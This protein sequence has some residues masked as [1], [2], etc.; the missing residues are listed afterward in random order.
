VMAR[1]PPKSEEHRVALQEVMRRD[2][3]LDEVVGVESE[4]YEGYVYDLMMPGEPHNYFSDGVFSHNCIDEIDKMRPEDRSAI[5]E[6]MEQQSYHPSF[7][8][9]F[10][11]G[12]KSRIGDFVDR[13]M[14]ARA[15]DVVRGVDCEIL[16]AR[17]M[18]ILINTTNFR[19]TYAVEVDRVSRHVA[20]DHFIRITYSNGRSIIVT[21]N[22]RSL[23]S[24]TARSRQGVLKR[25]AL[26]ISPQRHARSIIVAKRNSAPPW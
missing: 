24:R 5:H 16:D 2:Y 18:R 25:F 6:A 15:M 14:G 10:A 4:C 26:E 23:C 13:L 22:T 7:E 3:F 19:D 1:M 12:S 11:D 8:I 21:L 20:P 9:A 17:G